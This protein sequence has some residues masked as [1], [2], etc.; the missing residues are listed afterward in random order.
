[1]MKLNKPFE[2]SSRL[3]PSVKVGGA[4]ISLECGRTNSEGRTIYKAF[5]DLPNGKEY[6]VNYLKSGCQG[7]TIQEG[8]ESLLSFLGAAADSYAHR[9]RTGCVSENEDLFEPEIVEWAY[10]NSD[11]ITCLELELQEHKELIED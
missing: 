8:M 5:I 4:T 6:A 10:Q 2:I 7:G 11:E 9:I 3:M 1:M